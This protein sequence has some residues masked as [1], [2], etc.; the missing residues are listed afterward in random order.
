MNV[1]Y[2][3]YQRQILLKEFGE[4]G[5]QKLQQAKVLVIGAGG[6]GC[7]ALQYLAAAGIGHI[8]I[9][10]DDIVSLS[11]LHRQVLYTVNDIGL[12]KAVK[13][14]AILQNRNPEIKV[15]A[16]PER[17]TSKNALAI[18]SDYEMVIDATDNF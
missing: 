16:Y 12:P 2:E 3:R 10:D 7:P 1:Q 4:A 14:A 5:Q 8:G 13:A 18:I 9:V 11:D 15:V 6:L 17:L